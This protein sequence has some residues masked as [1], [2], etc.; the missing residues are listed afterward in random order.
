MPRRRPAVVALALAVT[1]AFVPTYL[2]HATP[3]SDHEFAA[4]RLPRPQRSP[5]AGARD[6]D[7]H[8]V[9]VRFK[10]DAAR[11]A[12]DR[13]LSRRGARSLAS[14]AGTRFVKVRAE[15]SA[16]DLLRSL[17]KDPAV[18]A[19][20]LDHKRSAT[21]APKD[22]AYASGDQ[23]YLNTVRLP[24]AWDRAK[25]STSQVIAVLDTGVNTA[26]PDLAGR[27]V[28][29][30]NAINPSRL[31]TDDNGHGTM[32]AGVAAANT[33]NGIGVA[34]AAW[35][36]RI[37]PVKVLAADGSGYDS[38]I[39]AG[40]TWAADHGAKIINMSLGGPDDNAVLQDAIRYATAKGAV[41]VAAAGNDG[42]GSAQ[43]PAAYP[44]VISVGATDAA[45]RLTDFSSYGDWID[46][47][48]PGAGI[49]STGLGR[50]YYV[51]DGTSFSAPLVSG[52][53][54]LV[55]AAYP[56]LTPAQVLARIQSTARD[57]GP[58]GIDPY[59]GH[60]VLDAFAAVGGT[61]GAEFPAP[62]LGA[63]EPNDV[64]AR[65]TALAA[66]AT[67]TIAAEGDV[68]WYRYASDGNQVV[69]VTV[70]PAAY[71]GARAQNVDPVLALYD[72]DLRLIGEADATGPGETEKLSATIAAGVHYVSVR[73]Y[74][75]AADTR[76]YTV[77][78]KTVPAPQF[79][80]PQSTRVGSWPETVAIGDVTGDGRPDAIMATGFDSDEAN[81]YTL[82]VFPQRPDGALGAPVRYAT[83]LQ[84]ADAGG[85]GLAVLDVNGDDRQDVALA[86]K[87]GVE[88]FRQTGEGTLE[89][90]G[91]LP[92]TTGSGGVVAADMDGDGDTDLVV[93]GEA[94]ILL[95]TQQ[96]DGTFT[97]S[98]V[99]TDGT[100]EVEVGDVDG[101]GRTDVVAASGA[102]VRVYHRTDTGWDRTEHPTG[103]TEGTRGIEVAD[104]S[105]DGRVDVVASLGGTRPS[106]NVAVLRQNA[107]GGLDPAQLLPVAD[108]PGPIEAADVNADGRADVV[109]AHGGWATLSVLPQLSDGSLG[110]PVGSA[111]P[112][113]SHY[114]A[115]GM[116]LGDINGDERADVVIAD[117]NSGLV[118][119]HNGAGVSPVGEQQWVRDVA[120]ADFAVGAPLDVQP[121]VTFAR[122][123]DPA[124]VT[125]S[126][127][128][129][130]N[131]RTGAAVPATSSLTGS[132]VTLTPDTALQDNTPYRIVVGGLKD[133][134]GT[135]QTAPFSTTFRTVDLA[136]AAVD[137]LTATGAYQAATLGWTLPDITDL[138]QVIVRWSAG[139]TA[140]TSVTAGN[141][142]Y[143]G[144][145]TAAVVR[146]LVGG[147]TYSF[148]VWVRD[149]SGAYSPV[150]TTQLG[151]TAVTITSRVSMVTYGGAVTLTGVLTQRDT[152]APLAGQPVQL[153]GRARGT[154]AFAVLGTVTSSG[155]GAVAF[156]HRPSR[157][158]EYQWVYAGPGDRV[159][160]GSSLRAV[161]VASTVTAAAS[162]S[163]FR[164]GGSLV[165]SGKV[166]PS[167]ARQTV[168]LQRLVGGSWRNVTSRSLS[169]TSSYSFTVEPT[170][171]GTYQYRVYKPA[172]ADHVGAASVP[173]SV[174]VT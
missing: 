50:E 99:T 75:G 13:A 85:A 153:Y 151:G 97:S 71:D 21:V 159:G 161:N 119:L 11:S 45:G 87:A 105:G 6:F 3:S 150:A 40:V 91:T 166:S 121:T 137:T 134:S 52:T 120:P 141:A 94:G 96:P 127:V 9:L 68:D 124:T 98:S 80:P 113:A 14:V 32:A 24:Q 136:P 115:Q 162:K 7:P 62:A 59:Y 48:A 22:P 135:A 42:D 79:A 100:P 12:N 163:S 143:A 110:P 19:V 47:A 30:Y 16:I 57:A 20:S 140:P 116:A 160:A 93:R 154:T 2:A 33:N 73:N 146:G 84:G 86:T 90:T 4:T 36:A 63:N 158:F 174:K 83:R 49:V 167:H 92:D 8:A 132:T 165:L 78:V 31:P 144:V 34:G 149:R 126:T 164:L 148:A 69:E 131:G 152:G 70:T 171:R 67:G 27:T 142:G 168:Y 172:D 76:P 95:L 169:S 37:M 130:V 72:P 10:S 88:L 41:V 74:N 101:D 156:S 55:R 157:N 117:D 1:G 170:T 133:S 25:G 38:H 65:A 15:G 111:I 112:Y 28:A 58:R 106:A 145:G 44:E 89:S 43:Y 82:F 77:S 51:A 66:R 103:S 128:R 129:L 155:T 17:Q 104:V 54:A 56:S 26:H 29:G 35:T 5:D 61:W 39:A 23:S 81:D 139:A 122:E 18:A 60:G 173:R 138:D 53:V 114:N 147:G 107:T 109:T 46:V 123:I 108:A 118:V 64:P 102:T 125:P